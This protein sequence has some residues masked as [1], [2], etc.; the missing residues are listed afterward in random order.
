MPFLADCPLLRASLPWS[1]RMDE[2]HWRAFPK[3]NH[4]NNGTNLWP[5]VVCQRAR[6]QPLVKRLYFLSKMSLLFC[7]KG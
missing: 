7:L 4:F 3:L 6:A 2:P 1:R 5:E